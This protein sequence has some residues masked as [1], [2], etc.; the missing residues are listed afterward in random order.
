[1]TRMRALLVAT[2]AVSLLLALPLRRRTRALLVATL[3]GSLLLAAQKRRRS[4]AEAISEATDRVVR[5]TPPLR[6][7]LRR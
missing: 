6:R 1:M 5:T 7:G 2:L 4:P 3:A